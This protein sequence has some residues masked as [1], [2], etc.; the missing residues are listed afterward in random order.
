LFY[1]EKPQNGLL[2]TGFEMHTYS[3]AGELLCS[4]RRPAQGISKPIP[5]TP[6]CDFLSF[7]LSHIQKS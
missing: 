2:G 6:F 7:I 1:N 5:S 4:A 3:P